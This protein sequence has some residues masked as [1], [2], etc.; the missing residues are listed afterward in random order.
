M[1]RQSPAE[2]AY[3]MTLARPFNIKTR[4]YK[5]NTF[6]SFQRHGTREKKRHF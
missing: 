1:Q 6:N 2:T 5:A 4:Y 3:T